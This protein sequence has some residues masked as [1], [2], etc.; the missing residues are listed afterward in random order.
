MNSSHNVVV[1]A[2]AGCGKTYW[3]VHAICDGLENGTISMKS[4]VAIT[5]TRRAAGDLRTRL[6]LEIQERI[7]N[8]R[9]GLTASLE[10]MG[11]AKIG[12]IHSFCAS[13]L[14][15]R[16]LE[17]RVDPAFRPMEEDE[18][19]AVFE[20]CF[21]TWVAANLDKYANFFRAFVVGL[22]RSI[23]TTEYSEYQDNSL[24]GFFRR[25][26]DHRELEHDQP[27]APA[28]S[29][30]QI[31]KESTKKMKALLKASEW[32]KVTEKMTE[33]LKALSE[34]ESNVDEILRIRYR[35]GNA[36]GSKA[37]AVRNE[38]HQ[39]WEEFLVAFPY[40]HFYPEIKVVHE[41]AARAAKDFVEYYREHLRI[42]GK[43]DH[44]DILIRAEELLRT[45]RDARNY[46][47]ERYQHYFVDEFQDTD[48]MQVRIL[49]YLC[50]KP[51]NFAEQWD[52]TELEPGR[53]AVVGDP[54]QSIYGFRRADIEMFTAMTERI[55]PKSS[56]H[57]VPLTQSR[58]SRKEVIDWV[59]NA[60]RSRMK[61]PA[62]GN[63]QADFVDLEPHGKTESGGVV[64]L[65]R[66]DLPL[67]GVKIDVVRDAEARLTAQR[68]HE[69]IEQGHSPGEFL[70]LFRA[71]KNMTRTAD[72]LEGLNVPFEL[73]GGSVYFG[74]MEV[75]EMSNLMSAIALPHLSHLVVAALKGP[76]FSLT[77]R[78]LFDWHEAAGA[79]DLYPWSYESLPETA[80]ANC[81]GLPAW[82]ALSDLKQWRSQSRNESPQRIF[83]QILMEKGILASIASSA[84]GQQR[85]LNILR[86]GELLRSW[87]GSTFLEAVERLREAC[88]ENE[89]LSEVTLARS[90]EDGVRL[91]TIH[92][93]KGLESEIVVLADATSAKE[94]ANDWIINPTTHKLTYCLYPVEYPE[95]KKLREAD[96]LRSA[97]E[98]ERLRYVAATRAKS[99]LIV[100]DVE[101]TATRDTDNP[102]TRFI[103]P[104]RQVEQGATRVE[105]ED[106]PELTT[107]AS[108]SP[109][110]VTPKPNAAF[111]K[112]SDKISEEIPAAVSVLSVPGFDPV[113][114]SSLRGPA[115][116]HIEIRVETVSDDGSPGLTAIP[117]R[118]AT[119]GT[120]VHRLLELD[121][122]D[123]R[124]S[125][126]ALLHGESE[127]LRAKADEIAD[128]AERFRATET[129]QR[130]KKARR[131]LR[132]LPIQFTDADGTRYDGVIDLLFEEEDGWVLVDYKIVELENEEDRKRLLQEYGKQMEAYDRGFKAMGIKVKERVILGV[133]RGAVVV[134]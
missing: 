128:L 124:A 71:T 114:P 132:E 12:T 28:V 84:R 59:N 43:I 102:G 47:K 33:Q 39:L 88:Q 41:D 68:I 87:S 11:S 37:D 64:E 131:I 31:L 77:D 106:D 120:L 49:S 57:R 5:F 14:R 81:V 104:L 98:S 94:R 83:Q 61:R 58:R 85:V 133:E 118:R 130:L 32:P 108:W 75:R 18:A 65:A 30:P 20:N 13:L 92:G 111:R 8:G 117:V 40:A 55:A 26:L 82:A 46:F 76:A 67:D 90:G 23:F 29:A 51:G 70:V 123:M 96:L 17:A 3:I 45:N 15:E 7:K 52:K 103:F 63:Y 116:D 54:R 101:Y 16:P 34:A 35:L 21:R 91:L 110:K 2:G 36:G 105:V 10:A 56:G 48:P 38:W 125:I 80:P 73:E 97:A 89:K 27:G 60:F 79:A 6:A 107:D 121:P 93:A 4:L 24:Q 122:P 127:T 44:T 72:Y 99:R 66:I 19:D 69:L 134:V 126:R 119:V 74:R 53:L 50:E 9:A 113:S 100:N 109:M 95:W 22:R 25:I 112:E 129:L 62:D 42:E 78:D 1:E 115:D 86:I